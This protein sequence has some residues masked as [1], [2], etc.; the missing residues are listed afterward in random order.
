MKNRVYYGEYSLKHWID[1]IL[2]KNIVLPDYQRYFVWTEKK[3]TTLIEAFKKKQ[4]IPPITIGA[5]NKGDSVQNL[6]IDGQQRLTSLL[7]AY[8]GLFP[9]KMIYKSTLEK[10]ANENDDSEGEEQL[11]S[12]IDWTFKKLTSKG[13][14]KEA[15]LEKI[16]VGNYKT[17]NFN[18]SDNFLNNVFLGFSY[19]VPSTK[20]EK[21]QQKYYSAVFRSINIQGTPLTPQESREALYFSEKGFEEFFNPNFI[22]LLSVK[23][24]GDVTK[25]DFVRFLSLLSQYEKDG[26]VNN[27]A[28]GYKKS[29]MEEYYE[30]YIHSVFDETKSSVFKEF[31]VIF[32]NK[33]FN[34][35]F[36]NLK[37]VINS[38]EIPNEFTSIIELD[39]YLFGLIYSIVFR[40]KS[41]NTDER[42][43]LKKNLTD[44]F[45]DFKQDTSHTK[46][47]SA[48]KYL[49]LRISESIKIYNNYENEQS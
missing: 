36:E 38:L 5:F 31:S 12:I 16:I 19:L 13:T 23:S 25:A 18:V 11:D 6:I 7:L 4:F 1:L 45:I 30:D 40:N 17:Q 29:R 15:I 48:L 10:F 35:R 14:S 24:V 26:S 43:N 41:I 8:L 21:L 22:K 44:K 47:P 39:I 2:K 37:N 33:E 42:E 3:V 34:N 27:I 28:K 9:D 46:T 20:D 49:R 32:P